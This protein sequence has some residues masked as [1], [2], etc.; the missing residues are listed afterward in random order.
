[1]TRAPRQPFD[2]YARHCLEG[3]PNAIVAW[4]L[5]ASYL[6]YH[7][8]QVLITD[9]CFDE[10]CRDLLARWDEIEHPHKHLIDRAALEAG[11]GYHLREADY[12]RMVIGAAATLVEYGPP[13][14]FAHAA[15]PRLADAG[16]SAGAGQRPGSPCSLAACGGQEV[17]SKPAAAAPAQGELF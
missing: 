7:T 12:P 1:M 3:A 2:D 5:M 11:T 17:E 10:L 9:G 16:G 13:D 8:D 14:D 15:D 4:W 6:Y